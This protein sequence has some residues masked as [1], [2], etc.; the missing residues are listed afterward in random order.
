MTREANKQA[1]RDATGFEAAKDSNLAGRRMSGHYWD[2]T[3]GL[4]RVKA[5]LSR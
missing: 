3:S 4:C 1:T 5:A 2:R